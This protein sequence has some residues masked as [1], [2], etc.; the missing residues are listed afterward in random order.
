MLVFLLAALATELHVKV[1]SANPFM[2]LGS[3]S[4]DPGPPTVNIQSP[5]D[6]TNSPSGNNVWLN[7][8]VKAPITEWYSTKQGY[9][10]P[11]HYA[12]TFGN[13]TQVLYSLDGKP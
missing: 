13:V 11:D 10:Y 7:F 8:T 12:T 9:L 4:N 1:A 5:T 6:S 3:W 2:P